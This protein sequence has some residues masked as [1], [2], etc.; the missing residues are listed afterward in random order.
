MK[1][2]FCTGGKGGVG[3]SFVAA[4]VAGLYDA[5]G[6]EAYVVDADFRTADVSARYPERS[7]RV[8]LNAERGWRLLSDVIERLDAPVVVNMGADVSNVEERYAA[9]AA[10]TFHAA[11]GEVALIWVLTPAPE[12]LA[13]LAESARRGVM[14]RAGIKKIVAMNLIEEGLAVEDF[15]QYQRSPVREGL[16]KGGTLE[17]TVPHLF[18]DYALALRGRPLSLAADGFAQGLNLFGRMRVRKWWQEMSAGLA[19]ALGI[20]IP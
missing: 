5:A 7:V 13:H 11:G 4:C 1:V 17:V 9:D 2:T 14:R 12:S 18:R 3:K 6:A 8:D 20:E 15:D 10:E 19:P 16:V